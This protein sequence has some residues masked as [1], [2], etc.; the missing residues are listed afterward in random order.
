MALHHLTQFGDQVGQA[1]LG[2]AQAHAE[3]QIIG[4]QGFPRP[5]AGR[6]RC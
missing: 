1:E 6:R 4:E 2:V 5:Y 3:H